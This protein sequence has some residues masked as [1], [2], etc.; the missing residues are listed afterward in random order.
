M[1][2]LHA[3][4]LHQGGQVSNI[5]QLIPELNEMQR[6]CHWLAQWGWSEASG[7]NFSIRLNTLPDSVLNLSGE[8]PKP[9]PHHTP[10]LGGGYLLIS[11]RGARAR[12]LALDPEAGVGLYWIMQSGKEF[13]CLWGNSDPTSE[14]SAHLAI[15]TS[16]SRTRPKHTAI[17]HSHPPNLIALTHWPGFERGTDLSD[18]LLR[19]QSEARLHLPEGI[20]R[21]GFH[22]PGS[23]E[24]GP[25][26]AAA[27]MK[28]PVL[29]WHMH[30]AISTGE[31]ISSA[32]D[33]LEIVDKAAQIYWILTSAGMTPE[34]MTD[35]DQRRSLEH[36]K[37]WERY[38]SSKD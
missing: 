32:L 8:P 14:L 27:L 11:A 21:L 25:A 28:T 33:Y 6:V 34:G 24:L 36:F 3:N 15:Q 7:G 4:L 9:L 19:M 18:I 31:T 2:M 23:R 29:L 12:D 20:A 37:L 10:A 16:L 38:R 30:G 5:I 26:S 22:I 1:Q 17:L 13:T 35:D